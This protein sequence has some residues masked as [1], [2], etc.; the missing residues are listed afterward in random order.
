MEKF[1][2]NIENTNAEVFARIMKSTAS[3]YDCSVDIDF[4]DGKRDIRFV[5]DNAVKRHVVK[6]V[7]DIFE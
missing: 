6:E 2:V 3:K 4:N 7:A 1:R 5:G